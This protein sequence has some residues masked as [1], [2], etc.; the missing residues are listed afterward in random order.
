MNYSDVNLCDD[1]ILSCTKYILMQQDSH[2]EE[3]NDM[4]QRILGN[5]CSMSEILKT[6]MWKC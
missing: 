2:S 3:K 6:N 4:Y 5:F 1:D